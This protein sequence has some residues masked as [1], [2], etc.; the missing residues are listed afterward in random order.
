[1]PREI[2]LLGHRITPETKRLTSQATETPAPETEVT[3]RSHAIFAG[4]NLNPPPWSVRR[5][6][7]APVGSERATDSGSR[8]RRAYKEERGR[9]KSFIESYTS[10]VDIWDLLSLW[11]QLVFGKVLNHSRGRENPPSQ[12]RT[13]GFNVGGGPCWS[14]RLFVRSRVPAVS[15][16]HARFFY[17]LWYL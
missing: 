10:R 3:V 16:C 14:Y 7:L 4:R 5:R 17:R 15:Q 2:A 12:D 11:L 8:K 6:L 9:K 1:M 13:D